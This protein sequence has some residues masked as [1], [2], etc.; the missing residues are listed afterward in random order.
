MK[1]IV[2]DPVSRIEGHLRVEV[3]LDGQEV[4]DAKSSGTMFRGFE[5]ILI[6]RHPM[7]ASQIAQRV[8]G[9][10]PIAH[11]SASTFA[12]DAAFGVADKIPDNGRIIR[13]LI[14][15]SNV[16]QSH[17]LH[18]YHLS[19]LDYVDIAAAADYA[20]DNEDLQSVREFIG[21]GQ[22][23]PFMP[24]YEGDY[25]LPKE[26]NVAATAHYAKA[27]QIRRMAHEML[28][29]FGGKMPHQCA[30]VAGGVTDGPS[31]SK[32]ASFLGRLETIRRFINDCYLPDVLAVAGAYADHCA[33]GQGCG[34]FLSYGMFDQTATSAPLRLKPRF[35]RSGTFADGQVADLDMSQITEAVTHSHF[36]GDGPLRPSEETTIPQLGKQ[37]AYSWLKAPR[38]NDAVYEVGPLAAMVVNYHGG[39][40]A[41]KAAV[42]SA[43]AAL[44]ATADALPSVMGR[45]LARALHAKLIADAMP[46]WVLRLK[47]GEPHCAEYA[48]PDEGRG[49]GATD[50]PRGA[51]AH[52]LRVKDKKIASY[53]LVVPTTW[54]AS[55]QDDQGRPGPMEQALIGTKVRD[56]ENPF[57]IVR[58]VRA[59]DPCLACAVHVVTPK[60]RS[61]GEFRIA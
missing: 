19:A 8:C 10:C 31:T 34:R 24:R 56:A 1:K 5:Q 25:R 43:L 46:G 18:F 7:D 60:G 39:N 49:Y 51:V 20:G 27:L 37:G 21:R 14:L 41:V 38:Y 13:N 16:L 35:L 12:L 52:W 32:I 33:I 2:I 15:A 17:I 3:T 58:I 47:P 48:I 29:V 40:A 26:I 54:N 4:K 9:V 53:Q 61:L 55:P 22:P 30:I 50:A 45:H 59:F 23:A 28:S 11:A 6:G 44:G 57:E 42:D 36:E